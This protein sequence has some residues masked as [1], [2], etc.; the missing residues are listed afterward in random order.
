MPVFPAELA[1]IACEA[2]A[3]QGGQQL[4][5]QPFRWIARDVD[6]P[7]VER[8]DRA[9]TARNRRNIGTDWPFVDVFAN[10]RGCWYQA[11][12]TEWF[13]GGPIADVITTIAM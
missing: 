6:Q 8:Q 10:E 1:E 13:G 2:V 11:P 4:I 9:Q 3:R 12:T 7:I 5:D